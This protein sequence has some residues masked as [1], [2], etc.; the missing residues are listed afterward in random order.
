[1]GAPILLLLVLMMTAW[2][3]DRAPGT[4]APAF[5]VT[6]PVQYGRVM[7][8]LNWA[9]V[10]AMGL[11]LLSCKVALPRPIRWMAPVLSMIALI[12]G[13]VECRL[14]AEARSHAV[15]RG[16]RHP[17]LFASTDDC[18]KGWRGGGSRSPGPCVH[19][20]RLWDGR[21][22]YDVTGRDYAKVRACVIVQRIADRSGFTWDEVVAQ[23][24][25]RAETDD[26][27]DITQDAQRDCVSGVSLPASER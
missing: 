14:V 20:F 19:A 23:L 24:D 26:K 8:W 12:G 25:L 3:V 5:A 15:I 9:M 13:F 6:V 18:G 27:G 7:S 4:V 11:L 1:M 21:S 16:P 22:A 2:L 17:M 10:G